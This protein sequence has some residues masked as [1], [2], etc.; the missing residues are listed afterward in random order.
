MAIR[1]FDLDAP[2]L[3]RLERSEFRYRTRAISGMVEDIL[4]GKIYLG[5]SWKVLV[6]V[7]PTVE[8]D[9]H[10]NLIGV[11]V[12]QVK[13]D[14]GAIF[15]GDNSYRGELSLSWLLEGV[16]KLLSET[17]VPDVELDGVAI[18]V[19][20]SM[21]IRTKKWRGPV[22]SRDGRY[23]AEVVVESDSDAA[24]VVGIVRE[25]NGDIVSKKILYLERPD[26]FIYAS[27]IGSLR[28][29]EYGVAQLF[30]KDGFKKVDIFRIQ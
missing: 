16:K 14:P 26:E 4:A 1:E 30:S 5:K 2:T 8:F 18:G 9:F 21:Y 10:R 6:E 23:A 12:L 28:W 29:N 17:N 25:R 20:Q 13:G 24:K 15:E 3:S 27:S 11:L 7:V 22:N 19:R